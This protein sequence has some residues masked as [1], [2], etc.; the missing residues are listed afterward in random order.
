MNIFIIGKR[1]IGKT[2]L[3]HNLVSGKRYI[4]YTEFNEDMLSDI[5]ENQKIILSPLIIVFENCCLQSPKFFKN[6]IIRDL[7]INHKNLQISLIITLQ[8]L[9]DVPHDLEKYIDYLYCFMDNIPA[10]QKRLIKFAP[11]CNLENYNYLIIDNKNKKVS[12]SDNSIIF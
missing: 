1:S 7:F 4:I 11:Y 8:Y 2:T 12:C 10:N 5:I 9:V 6:K 3:I